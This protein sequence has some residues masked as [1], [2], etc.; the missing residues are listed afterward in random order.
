MERNTPQRQAIRS[1][2]DRIER[3]L[4]PAEVLDL[5]KEDAPSLSLATVYRTLKGLVDADEL[6]PVDVP[7]EPPRYERA[8]KDHHHHFHCR[9]CGKVFEVHGCAHG[10]TKLAPAGFVVEGHE[11]TLRGLCQQCARKAG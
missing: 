10:V 7:G 4:A 8:G 3:P 2:F 5:A 1:V 9:S 11:I 6:V